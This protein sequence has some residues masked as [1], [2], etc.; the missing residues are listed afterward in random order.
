MLKTQLQEELAGSYG[1][2]GQNGVAALR[3]PYVP[4]GASG[5]TYGT[6]DLGK[7]YFGSGGG[8]GGKGKDGT[9]STGGN[10]GGIVMITA[11]SINVTGAIDARGGNALQDGRDGQSGGGGGG[12]GGSV[13][14][15]TIAGKC[16]QCEC[17]WWCS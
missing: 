3:P 5:N 1:T 16:K 9:G 6:V 8:G 13:L 4:G 12:A 15:Q 10:G 7:I 11:E 17:R 2:A 14:I